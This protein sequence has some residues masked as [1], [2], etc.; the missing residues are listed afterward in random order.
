MISYLLESCFI[1]IFFGVFGFFFHY[2]RMSE[3]KKKKVKNKIKCSL[4][5][6]WNFKKIKC[7]FTK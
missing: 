3:V 5:M 4:S 7:L 1:F 2:Q 6:I